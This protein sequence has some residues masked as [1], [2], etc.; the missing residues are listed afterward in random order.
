MEQARAGVRAWAREAGRRTGAGIRVATPYGILAFLTASAVAPVVGAGLGTSE[1]VGA[2]LNQL[3]GVGGNYLADTLSGVANRLRERDIP[4][5]PG[6]WRD[7]VAQALQPL[8]A[9]DGERAEGLRADVGRLLREV[10]AVQTALSAAAEADVQL[11]DALAG[12]FHT[13]G[14]DVGELRWMLTD[15][16]RA[17]DGLQHQLA[18]E[19]LRLHQRLDVLRQQMAIFTQLRQEPV[20]GGPPRRKR[21]GRADKSGPAAAGGAVCP[22]PGLASFQPEDARWFRGREHQVSTLLGR[23]A[24]QVVGGPPLVVTGVSGVGKSSL[25]RAG[26]LPA[27]AAGGLGE[28]ATAWPWLLMTPGPHPLADLVHRTQALTVPGT[29]GADLDTITD[30][31]QRYGEL[32]AQATRDGHRPV[33]MVDQCEE[34]FTQCA[35][36]AERLA[37]AAA[38]ASAAPALVVIAVRA[39]F[40]AA[41]TELPPL[42][43]VLAAGHVVLGP[44]EADDLRRAVVEPAARA[45]V[46]VEPGLPD[47]LLRDL[48]AAGAG[49][50][51]GALPLLAH[52]LR[53]TWERR[54]GNRLTVA[55][56]RTTGGIHHAVAAT[57]EEIYLDLDPEGRPRLRAALLDLVAVA[58][59]GT[60][61]RRRGDRDSIDPQVLDRLV[62]A[63]LV[64]AGQ[65]TVEISHEAL[66]TNWPRLAGWLVEA[67]EE[68]LLRQRLADAARDWADS[69]RDPDLLLRGARLAAASEWAGRGDLTSAQQEYLAHSTAAVLAAE[70]ARRRTTQRLRRL[71]VGLAAALLVAVAGGTVALDQRGEAEASSR[72]ALSRQ[73]AAESLHAGAQDE[74]TAVRKALDA[75]SQA[76][77]G[78]ARGALL[79][80]HNSNLVGQL[81]TAPGGLSAAMSPDGA[82][83]A[84]GHSDG[85]IRLWD[86]GTLAEDGPPLIHHVPA[87]SGDRTAWVTSVAFSSDGRYLASGAS[88]GVRIWDVPTWRLRHTLPGGGAVA[89]L[90]GTT[91]VL[92]TRSDTGD[93]PFQLGMWDAASGRRTRSLTTG[94]TTGLT[95]V[96]ASPDGRYVATVHPDGE[97]RVWRLA[98]G[99]STATV[100]GI[101]DV[102]FAPD[103]SLVTGGMDGQLAQWD[104][105]TG[106]RI[107]Q[108]TPPDVPRPA[109]RIAV[110]RDGVVI[111][112]ATVTAGV[113][114]QSVGLWPLTGQADGVLGGHDSSIVDVAA[115][116]NGK[117]LVVTGLAGPSSVFRR[118]TDRLNHP[119][120]A[121]SVAFDPAGARLATAA[122]DQRVRI[123][124]A[125]SHDLVATFGT[126]GRP[127]DLVYAA[128]G[129]LAVRTSHHVEV[130]DRAGRLQ[131]S[132]PTRYAT[133]D[134]AFSPDSA[135]LAI[136]VGPDLAEGEGE[137]EIVVWSVPGRA[138]QATLPTGQSTPYALAFTPDGDTLIASVTD[139][140]GGDDSAPR[141]A[142][143]LRT[144]RTADLAQVSTRDIGAYQ[145]LDLAVSPDGRTLALAG[146]NNAVEFRSVDGFGVTR[147]SPPLPGRVHAIAYAPDGRTLAS[148]TRD[149]VVRLW[150]TD[151]PAA[152]DGTTPAVAALTGH[153]DPVFAVAFAPDGRVLASASADATVA[154]WQLE[155][156]AAVDRL[157]RS[158]RAAARTEHRDPPRVCR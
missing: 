2:T 154:L 45:G 124:D 88:A 11:R 81:G 16:R 111:G 153:V 100:P 82:L 85:R 49:Y 148:A 5:S 12:A 44:L 35:D 4:P 20:A 74:Q 51:P 90:P 36:P 38:L 95:S 76:P 43:R 50:D 10:D 131:V 53:A 23:L 72:E 87:T 25:L 66:L 93:G 17:L 34:L 94:K 119:D 40:Y 46:A 101:W 75:W 149:G 1:A 134:L 126:A 150:R 132:I 158:V 129:T 91:T 9:A 19:S 48:G 156:Q 32:A 117:L 157:C 123:W 127:V 139:N 135:L 65:D 3:G 96:A 42:A 143:Q 105:R 63:R 114:V 110:T 155:P 86:T 58:E 47:L 15:A 116:A 70:D 67:R 138:V 112:Q 7:A 80:A 125:T 89:W 103:G 69:G 33:I 144:W 128:D 68:I 113:E 54:D 26:L 21:S 37:F 14:S 59:G 92:A 108:L 30:Q 52:A 64:T 122:A 13:L 147:T 31:P 24:E 78:E 152:P 133:H 102:A 61:V 60:V 120:G 29:D 97:S 57:A 137:G 62:S 107:R 56:Y 151:G 104:A 27:I 39:D 41:C 73:Y 118:A 71:A 141:Q 84:I 109:A 98:D 136:A 18:A 140:T 8:L 79:S 145:P 146:N 121:L 130:R 115:S 28:A 22:Y 99:R 77:T 142:S 55:G 83:V 106:R 6:E